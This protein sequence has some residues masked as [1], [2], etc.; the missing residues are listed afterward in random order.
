MVA[1][2]LETSITTWIAAQ[3]EE[4]GTITLPAKLLAE[5]INALTTEC[6]EL[7][8]PVDTHTVQVSTG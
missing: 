6:V 7:V 2:N 3:V 8:K 4:E 1:T 5:L